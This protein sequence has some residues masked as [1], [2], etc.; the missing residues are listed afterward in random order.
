M[1]NEKQINPSKFLRERIEQAL[2]QRQ[3]II[4]PDL[5]S[6][7]Q[8]D[9]II[10]KTIWVPARLKDAIIEKCQNC[11][12]NSYLIAALD[13]LFRSNNEESQLKKRVEILEK[14]LQA[15][16][17]ELWFLSVENDLNMKSRFDPKKFFD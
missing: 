8:N 11:T 9:E 10:E 16:Q 4:D 6:K 12:I 1:L 3:L 5:F 2:K 7:T 14:K 17:E 13:S 15:L